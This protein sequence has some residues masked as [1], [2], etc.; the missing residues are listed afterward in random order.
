MIIHVGPPA[1]QPTYAT[2]IMPIAGA[3]VQQP[4]A[5]NPLIGLAKIIR[6][7]PIL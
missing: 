2:T 4:L 1:L 6:V 5:Q 7:R 3:A